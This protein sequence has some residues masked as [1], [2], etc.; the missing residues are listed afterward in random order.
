MRRRSPWLWAAAFF[1]YAFLYAP[2]VIVVAYSFN[3]SRLNAEWVGF[4]FSWYGKLF[5]NEKMLGAAWN[6]LIIGLVAS[7]VATVL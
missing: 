2:L 7:A 3:D 1:A 5:H 6:S 4:T